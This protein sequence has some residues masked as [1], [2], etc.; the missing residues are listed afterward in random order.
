MRSRLR[1][2][3]FRWIYFGRDRRETI[4]LN[5]T[6]TIATRP[7]G[8]HKD[9]VS[10]IALGGG[11]LARPGLD[12]QEV[13]ETIQAAVDM[14]VT[15]IDT[16]WDY[17]D[18]ISE[19][20]MGRALSGRRDDVFLATKVCARDA[21]T[22]ANQIDESLIRLRTD[23][24]DLL[25][26]H[27]CNY[28]N[29]PDLIFQTDGAIHALLDAKETG[30]TRYIGFTGHKHPGILIDLLNRDVEWD[31]CQMPVSIFDSLFRSFANKILPIVTARGMACI[32]M[33]S[34]GGNGQFVTETDL[35]PEE[36]R[37]YALSQPITTLSCGITSMRDLTQDVSIG[38][39]FAAMSEQT[40]SNLRA[41]IHDVAIDGRHEW[42]KTNNFFDNAYHRNQHGYPEQANIRGKMGFPQ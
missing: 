39:S 24:V 27:E 9:Q 38:R 32:G 3:I 42:F 34:L 7:F 15:F 6:G 12:E 16:A 28:D 14:G 29:D 2:G 23:H 26:L 37:H 22:A 10:I 31:A 4:S 13:I 1:C 5:L 18:G 41:R 21:K 40:Q 25:Q 36:C 19:D 20:Y 30:K 33:K 17:G 35:T 11:H 8:S